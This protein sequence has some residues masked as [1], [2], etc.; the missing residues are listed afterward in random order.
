MDSNDS[1]E[2]KDEVNS[3]MSIEAIEEAKSLPH[4]TSEKP[5]ACGKCD[6]SFGRLH[7]LKSHSYVHS[8]ERPFQ[9][10]SCPQAFARQHD[11]KRHHRLHDGVKP[12]SCNFCNR[13]FSRQDALNRHL[14]VEGKKAPCVGLTKKTVVK[15]A[16]SSETPPRQQVSN[17]M[18]IISSVN[19]ANFDFNGTYFENMETNAV[20]DLLRKQVSLY[21]T[22]N[23]ML[24]KRVGELEMLIDANLVKKLETK[25]TELE[26]EKNLLKS[27]IIQK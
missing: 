2:G 24:T 6:Q 20:I 19:F 22:Q 1:S 13:N 7:N 5:F 16:E 9:C 14:R 8:G 23:E 10:D 26:I 25:I 27:M 11:L 4:A 21:Q 12:Y 18:P 17:P 15:P 3:G